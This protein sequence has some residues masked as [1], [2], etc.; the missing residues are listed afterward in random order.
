MARPIKIFSSEE[1]M[2][3]IRTFWL[4]S[5]SSDW[6]DFEKNLQVTEVSGISNREQLTKISADAK[7]ALDDLMNANDKDA[8]PA[9]I[10]AWIDTYLS[11]TGWKRIQAAKRQK[12]I[13]LSNRDLLTKM[14]KE[15]SW[16][17]SHLAEA[18]G[19]TKKDYLS[20]LAGWMINDKTGQKAAAAFSA[21]RK[22]PSEA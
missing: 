17:F 4:K 11:E 14:N 16:D 18:A 9:A 20:Q 13:A 12:K 22:A 3:L 19:L 8:A 1:S 7:T 6:Y 10:R 21:S 2:N 5:R 15:S